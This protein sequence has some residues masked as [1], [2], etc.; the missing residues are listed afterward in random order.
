MA[1]YNNK[2]EI[3]QGNSDTVFI[4]VL[5]S[6]SLAMDLTGY[7]GTM[8]VKKNRD[9][10]ISFQNNHT[11]KNDSEG[12]MTFEITTTDTSLAS[13]D[14]QYDITIDNSTNVFTVVQEQFI[15][16]DSVRY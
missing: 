2:I 15:I 7:T 14:Y 10:A 6:S 13:G 16:I 11:L 12:T 1:T 5:D 4:S 8:T 3:Y 9:D